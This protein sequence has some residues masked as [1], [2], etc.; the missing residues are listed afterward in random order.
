[1]YRL[2]VYRYKYDVCMPKADQLRLGRLDN[3]VQPTE[4][5]SKLDCDEFIVCRRV[6][7][8]TPA[9]KVAK[10]NESQSR[11]PGL[12]MFSLVS[13]LLLPEVKESVV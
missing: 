8:D 9:E 4:Y 1:M 7:A 10:R 2:S 11:S 13:S 3:I 6:F 5:I 12:F